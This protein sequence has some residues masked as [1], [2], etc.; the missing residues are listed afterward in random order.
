MLTDCECTP[1]LSEMIFRKAGVF[2]L[3]DKGKK[4]ILLLT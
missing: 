2:R 3:P 4:I 1:R